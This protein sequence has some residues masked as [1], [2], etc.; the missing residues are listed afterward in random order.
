MNTNEKRHERVEQIFTRAREIDAAPD[1]AQFLREACGNDEVLRAEIE[2]LLRAEQHPDSFLERAALGDLPETSPVEFPVNRLIGTSIGNYKL[3][4]KLGEGGMGTVFL[5]EQT[6]PIQRRVALKVVK[7]GM[8][9]KQFAARFEAERQALAM[10]DHP[11]ISRVYDAGC[12]DDGLPY[13]VM[14]LVKGIPITKFCNDSKLNAR[15]RL[16]L[17]LHVCNAVQHA[18]QKG[19]IHR[20]LK[21]SNVL[22][23][24]YDDRP[25]PKV[26]DFGVAKATNQR[27]TER[28]LFTMIG[29][30]V[31]TWEYMSPEQAVLNQLDVDTR[32]D[33][34]SLGVILYELLTGV[35]PID[36]QRLRTAGLE[37]TLRIIREEEPQKPSTRVSSM[38][39]SATTASGYQRT[40]TASLVSS[41]RGDLD[42]IVMKTLD[43]DRVRRYQ[44]ASD[45]AAD[46]G[47][48]LADEPVLARAPTSYDRLRRYV[49]R[50]WRL[51]ASLAAIFL[52]MACGLLVSLTSLSLARRNA[53]DAERSLAAVRDAAMMLAMT[54]TE[55]DVQRAIDL[56]RITRAHDFEI[57]ESMLRAQG[58]MARG[59]TDESI[60]FLEDALIQ[61]PENLSCRALLTWVHLLSGDWIAAARN[62]AEL[63]G[64]IPKTAE[65]HAFVAQATL[66]EP[67]R[68]ITHA[69]RALELRDSHVAEIA[70][71]MLNAIRA[72]DT[73]DGA[74]LPDVMARLR[75]LQQGVSNN[76]YVWSITLFCEIA[77]IQFARREGRD[78]DH[79]DQMHRNAREMIALLESVP[80]FVF[81]QSAIAMYYNEHG[82]QEEREATWE[83]IMRADSRGVLDNASY[84]F[85]TREDAAQAIEWI[86]RDDVYS[87]FSRELLR[88]AES[89]DV[90]NLL[91][92]YETHSRDQPVDYWLPFTYFAPLIAG[93]IDYLRRD[94]RAK[95]DAIQRGKLG[96]NAEID[97]RTLQVIA[98][99]ITPEEFLEFGGNSNVMR[100]HC[101]SILAFLALANKDR[102]LAKMHW[103]GVVD[104]GV[105][106]YGNYIWAKAS[107][108]HMVAD[109]SWPNWIEFATD[110]SSSR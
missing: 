103:R 83:N 24:M 71:C 17:F 41:L 82:T 69:E 108:R 3:L 107:L 30:I 104:A 6:H 48:H 52:V 21:P 47:R 66:T 77:N 110:K 89:D 62:L 4:Q 59:K 31:G 61:D 33:V 97:K 98:G 53:A 44:S 13:F 50:N 102:E 26:I 45:L 109:S 67:A 86:Q 22:V 2:E 78:A 54:G 46:I 37:E 95:L 74:R 99:D 101:H 60:R 27:L 92:F 35:T 68:A 1:R 10:M 70:Y 84:Q 29:Q 19:I 25:V 105:F 51:V 76:P 72:L 34:Y 40:E 56:V 12:T 57:W 36:G 64:A 91:R 32:S 100:T 96:Y 28:T 15:Q 7:L 8:D 16:E 81:G 94:A 43:K 49:R 73:G 88:L 38:A 23:A 55:A 106:H 90:E 14:E 42:W 87:Q 85:L 20:D 80:D 39:E 63:R 93:D 65:E 9:S 18:H 75:E 5:A 58:A 79:I 11:N